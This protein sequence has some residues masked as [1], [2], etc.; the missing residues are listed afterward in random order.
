MSDLV[1]RADAG[2]VRTLVLNDPDR[3]NPL[4]VALRT[5]LLEELTEAMED[6]EVRAVV[7]TGAGA[8]FSAGGDLSAMRRRPAAEALEL[9]ES[10]QAVVRTIL[11][12][13][14]PVVAHVEGAAFG[15]GVA[16]AAACDRVV[17]TTT[18]R[19]RATFT[20]VGLSGDM[21]IYW[22]LPRRVGPAWARRMLMFGDEVDG[23]RAVDI[24][25]AD[26]LAEPGEALAVT[27]AEAARVARGPRG[28]LAAVKDMLGTVGDR[29]AVLDAEA[30]TQSSLTDT[31]DFAEGVAAFRERRAPSFGEPS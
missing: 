21:G 18:T 11:A 2:S 25:L 4:S 5:H 13:P 23:S 30:R 20:G 6:P 1:L 17:T 7:L 12:G 24:G 31:D 16:L 3:R 15:A 27:A 29:D 10:A 26:V 22:S 8:V 19:F 14:V 9:L 28:A